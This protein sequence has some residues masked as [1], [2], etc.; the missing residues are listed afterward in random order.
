MK[1]T[2]EQWQDY[3]DSREFKHNRDDNEPK[4]LH[5]AIDD[6][7]DTVEELLSDFEEAMESQCVWGNCRRGCHPSYL[8]SEGYCS[9]ACH[10]GAPR[11]KYYTVK[12]S[13]CLNMK[14]A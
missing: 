4:T 13:Q 3:V 10:M 1:R 9:P 6:L 5:E 12:E 11:G 7:H 8:D 2:L 14:T